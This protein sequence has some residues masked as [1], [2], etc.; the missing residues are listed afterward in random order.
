MMVLAQNHLPEQLRKNKHISH[1]FSNRN[2]TALTFRCLYE[3][4]EVG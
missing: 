4:P 3:V 1:H 2:E